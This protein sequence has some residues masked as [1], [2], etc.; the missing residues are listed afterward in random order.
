MRTVTLITLS[1]ALKR[2]RMLS[3]LMLH[4]SGTLGGPASDCAVVVLG[5]WLD[6]AALVTAFFCGAST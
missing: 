4:L 6:P 1:E 3:L 5:G 2:L